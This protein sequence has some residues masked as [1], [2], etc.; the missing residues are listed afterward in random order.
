MLHRFMDHRSEHL[1]KN[2]LSDESDILRFLVRC[3]PQGIAAPNN[4]GDTPY[5][6][7]YPND[8][9]ARRLVLMSAAR[10]DPTR[11]LDGRP[12]K[13]ELRGEK[14]GAVRVFRLQKRVEHSQQDS[15]DFGWGADETHC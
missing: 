7:L 15:L 8:L 10:H 5:S 2:P 11:D 14:G 6:L 4:D 12:A 9:Y 3:F 13:F 1:R